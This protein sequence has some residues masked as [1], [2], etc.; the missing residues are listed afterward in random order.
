ML[1]GTGKGVI[2]ETEKSFFFQTIYAF[3][4]VYFDVYQLSSIKCIS[5][6]NNVMSSAKKI[7]VKQEKHVQESNSDGCL[8]RQEDV[9]N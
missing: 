4:Y 6:Q 5:S 7:P 8:V 1:G 9:Q 2:K 3:K